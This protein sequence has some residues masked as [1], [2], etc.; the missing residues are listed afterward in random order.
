MRERKQKQENCETK[1]GKNKLKG[2]SLGFIL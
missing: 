2:W 1:E